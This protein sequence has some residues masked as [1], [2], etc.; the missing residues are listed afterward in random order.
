MEVSQLVK[1]YKN[2]NLDFLKRKKMYVYIYSVKLPYYKFSQAIFAIDKCIEYN[3]IYSETSL[4]ISKNI[5]LKAICDQGD[6]LVY[7]IVLIII[8]KKL[9]YSLET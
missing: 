7:D 1:N 6:T 2:R 5:L 4:M 3:Y 8:L 9:N